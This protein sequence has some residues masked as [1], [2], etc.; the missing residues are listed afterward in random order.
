MALSNLLGGRNVYGDKVSA[1]RLV[2][3]CI[4]PGIFAAAYTYDKQQSLAVII[5]VWLSVTVGSA[6]WFAPNWSF[7][8]ITGKY[9]ATKYPAFIRWVGLKLFPLNVSA[10]R[11]RARGIVT[12]GLRGGFD[13]VTFG[14]L[15][16]INPIAPLWWLGTL[17]MGLIY[18]LAMRAFKEEFSVPAAEPIYGAWRGFLIVK[19]MGF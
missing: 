19:A 5:F 9:D 8:E 13:I 6:L 4:L 15:T 2:F 18:H 1:E 17:L 16:I 11:N 3:R 10:K 12:K 7:D 14:L